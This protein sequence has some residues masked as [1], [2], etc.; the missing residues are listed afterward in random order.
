MKRYFL[1]VCFSLLLT[2]AC[3]NQSTT[4]TESKH[5]Q[6]VQT[7]STVQAKTEHLNDILGYFKTYGFVIGAQSTKA[8]TMIG[9]SDGFGII[10]DGE[11]LE[12]YEFDSPDNTTLQQYKQ[13]GKLVTESAY[14]N[15]KFMLAG[16][17]DQKIVEAF[18][19]FK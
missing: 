15:G 1:V 17:P 6:S 14:V 10:I 8:Y 2:S 9:A 19:E 18:K 7:A 3:S 11:K 5:V 13:T 16:S 4:S 12:L